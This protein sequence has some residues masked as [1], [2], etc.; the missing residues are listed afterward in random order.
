MP[1]NYLLILIQS[2]SNNGYGLSTIIF[3]LILLSCLL[4]IW[5]IIKEKNKALEL[6][7]NPDQLTPPDD[8]KMVVA[9]IRDHVSNRTCNVEMDE[10]TFA[11]FHSQSRQV[12][13]Q[14]SQD[15]FK[16]KK[17]TMNGYYFQLGKRE[18]VED[19]HQ[20]D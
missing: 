9:E 4:V 8:K 6:E 13:R 15:L 11:W 19:G 12:R 7:D 3:L 5:A 20:A 17:V 10:E 14:L 18:A 2:S 16:G 1:N